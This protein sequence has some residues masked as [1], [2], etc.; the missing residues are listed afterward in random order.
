MPPKYV[1]TV[2]QLIYWEYAKLIARAAG[3]K[4]NYNWPE[5]SIPAQSGAV[6]S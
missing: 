5:C 6:P 3:F 1:T 4:D 2:R